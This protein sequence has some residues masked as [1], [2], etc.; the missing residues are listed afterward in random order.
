[1]QQQ[2]IDSQTQISLE[3]IDSELKEEPMKMCQ[4]ESPSNVGRPMVSTTNLGKAQEQADINKPY[5]EEEHSKTFQTWTVVKESRKSTWQPAWHIY[6]DTE[7][8]QYVMLIHG[9]EGEY[10]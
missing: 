9:L 6:I 7:H 4:A 3:N 1:M 8:G 2:N 10:E 5:V